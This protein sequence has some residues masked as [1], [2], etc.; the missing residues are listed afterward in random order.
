[1]NITFTK[2][3]GC[4]NDFILVDNRNMEIPHSQQPKLAKKLCRRKFDIGGD[5]LI[6]IEN[7]DLEQA[8][9][10]W[11]FYNADGSE[12]EMCGNGGRCAALFAFVNNIAPKDLAFETIAGVIQA[13]IIEDDRVKLQLTP[14][15]DLAQGLKLDL[16][17]NE[18]ALDCLNTG[19]PHACCFVDD[20]EL[21][22]VVGNGNEIR[23]HEK[24]S[25]NGTNVNFIQVT[26]QNS[27]SIRTYERGVEDET[28]ACGTGAV[29]AA[30]ISALNGFANSPV[31]V[32]TRGGDVLK[33]Y[34]NIDGD[35]I[36]EV[37]ME[38][39]AV[40]VCSGHTS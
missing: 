11:R 29:A 5:G 40:M 21:A 15:E 25:P 16:Q 28:L 38:G 32:L 23:F 12:A 24:F 35:R 1:M 3:H 13:S 18:A 8:D 33:I 4:G 20:I 30:I 19:V 14:P 27:I 39:P 6:F 26:G 36:K 37:F 17:N 9:F 2:M 10:K 22:D 34:F 7:P 31:D